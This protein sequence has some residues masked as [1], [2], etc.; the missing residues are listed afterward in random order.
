MRSIRST[1]LLHT[2][3]LDHL[4][5][6]VVGGDGVVQKRGDRERGHVEACY[7]GGESIQ[8]VV[9]VA[10]CLSKTISSLPAELTSC[11]KRQ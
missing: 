8:V 1:W 11:S 9:D 3:Q 10:S 5:A 2:G 6:S 7:G 4:E